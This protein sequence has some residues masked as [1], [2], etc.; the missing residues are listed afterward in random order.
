M[1]TDLLAVIG[2]FIIHTINDL[3]YVGVAI[4]MAIESAA[5]PLPSEIIMPFSGFLVLSGRFTIIYLSIA[6]AIGSVIGSV[7]TYALGYY[8]GRALILKY[9]RFVLISEHDLNLTEKF[10]KRFGKLSTFLGRVLPIFRTFISIPAGIGKVPLIPFIF[11]TFIGSFIWSYFL[12][13]LGFRLGENW[14]ILETYFR[15]FDL[16]I[17]LLIIIFIVWWIRRHFLSKNKS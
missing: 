1:I 17:G 4:L 5:I 10:F 3:G 8:G 14:Q 11:Y 15:K 2:G 13:W 9:G 6:G 12:A 7:I 16:L